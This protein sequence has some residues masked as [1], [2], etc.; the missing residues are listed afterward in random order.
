MTTPTSQPPLRRGL[1]TPVAGVC[2]GLARHLG[3]SV[4]VIRTVMIALTIAGGIGLILY[5]WLWAFVPVETEPEPEAARR[6]LSGPA[7]ENPDAGVPGSS[8]KPDAGGGTGS[9]A[10]PSGASGEEDFAAR[11]RRGLD[12]LTR[13]PEVLAG[14]LLLGIAGI[15]VLQLLGL[16]V[17]W[18]LIGPPAILVV[19]LLLA[20]SQ[21]DA[22]EGARTTR[23]RQAALWQ[24]AGGA[25]L[26]LVALLVMAGGFIP[27]GELILSL[28][29]AGMLLAGVALVI[30]P[31][32]IKMY[33]TMSVERARA[34]AEAER[35]D[36]A[37]HLHDSVL[38]TLAMIQKQRHDPAAVG[39]LARRQER[40][41]RDWL[42]RQQEARGQNPR[43]QE[44][45]G[46]QQ[47]G[48]AGVGEQ[49]QSLRDQLMAAAA[50]LEELY[51]VPVE[52]V[53][54]GESHREDHEALVAAAREA[55]VNA[56]KHAGPAAVYAESDERE[57]AVFIR[58]RGQGFDVDS[59][60]EDRLG[61]R[62]SIIGRMSRA[63]GRARIRSSESGTEV[64][65]FLPAEE[66]VSKETES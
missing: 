50:E 14:G 27:A 43:G 65:L 8:P 38:Q 19:G 25:F 32:L 34:A 54:V 9:R 11:L 16:R 10:G 12:V 61:V 49:P 24:F 21:V 57:D 29:L 6:G 52:V 1:D 63:G 66:R 39:Q 33:R 22:G 4:P 15:M 3:V 45:R 18:W 62:E 46:A 26:V 35:A 51:T 7:V 42:Y 5:C 2:L 41:L 37:A 58:D 40:Q 13:S 36:I 55:I 31:W 64:Q 20:W 48:E 47:P 60:E 44:T 59:I 53:T 28:V 23:S 17:D 30:A 56:L